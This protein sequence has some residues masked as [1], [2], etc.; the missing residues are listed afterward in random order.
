MFLE[1]LLITTLW[2]QIKV[3]KLVVYKKPAVKSPTLIFTVFSFFQHFDRKLIDTLSDIVELHK[4]SKIY[5]KMV[6]FSK[7]NYISHVNVAITKILKMTAKLF[8]W[9]IFCKRL[10]YVTLISNNKVAIRAYSRNCKNSI[11]QI[12][13]T[14]IY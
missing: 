11:F 5:L 2:I 6:V 13:T 9:P 12:S 1:Y 10:T 4:K 3:N 8:Q 14:Y 7:T